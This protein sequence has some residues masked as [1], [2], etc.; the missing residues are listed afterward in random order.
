VGAFD[1]GNGI[2]VVLAARNEATC[3]AKVLAQIKNVGLK[4]VEVIIVD[5]CSS[6]STSQVAE[7][8]GAVVLRNSRRLGQTA[9]LRKGHSVARGDVIITM[10]ADG[11]HDPQDIPRFL[12]ALKRNGRCL[13][14]GRRVALPRVSESILSMV[15]GPV[16]G[17]SDVICG[18]RASPREILK[19]ADFDRKETWGVKFLLSCSNRGVHIL[20]VP[21]RKSAARASARIGGKVSGNLKVIRCLIVGVTYLVRLRL[22]RVFGNIVNPAPQ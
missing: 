6:D 12:E 8:A 22:G 7:F 18:L 9:S 13:V 20:E 3:L 16:L 14:V 21:L 19:I 17:V 15:L 1:L 5:D 4:S 11:E 10:D 2:S